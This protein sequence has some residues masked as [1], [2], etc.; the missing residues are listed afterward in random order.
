MCHKLRK[1]LHGRMC[2]R[3]GRWEGGHKVYQGVHRFIRCTKECV[4]MMW[5]SVWT[6]CV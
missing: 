2:K 4:K 6:G 1:R 3:G 5:Q